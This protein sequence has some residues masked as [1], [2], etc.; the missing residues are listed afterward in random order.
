MLSI[1]SSSASPSPAPSASASP[2]L[3][4]AVT[5]TLTLTAP[6]VPLPPPPKDPPPSAPAAKRLPNESTRAMWYW[7]AEDVL[8][9][10][11][12]IRI[13]DFAAAPHG[14]RSRR[15]DRLFVEVSPSSLAGQDERRTRHFLASAHERGMQVELLAGAA[16][17]V[18]D[19]EKHVPKQICSDVAAYNSRNADA[20]FDGVHFDI[21]PHTLP[22][23]LW[24]ERPS[25]VPGD[26]RYNA[27]LKAN[28]IEI[29]RFCK[30]V[31]STSAPG[32]TLSADLGT[33]YAYYVH[34][35]W[36][37]LNNNETLLDYITIMNY[38]ATLEQWLLGA[39][40]TASLDGALYNIGA[41]SVP[42]LVGVETIPPP[43][44]PAEISFW[45]LGHEALHTMLELG[46]AEILA[47]P[48]AAKFGGV[49]I[50]HFES[51]HRMAAKKEGEGGLSCSAS[52][53]I[54]RVTGVEESIQC[55]L[56]YASSGQAHFARPSHDGVAIYN[57]Y[58][59]APVTIEFYR[60]IKN[61]AEIDC[62]GFVG[63][64]QC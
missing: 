10:D 26:D 18:L 54:L 56:F 23:G 45:A 42:V 12:G 20:A 9:T 64:H 57:A 38:F 7:S 17:W 48:S 44:A 15:I 31:L 1:V 36:K 13:L 24:R 58:A 43:H 21:E 63:D 47:Q 19:A 40:R 41:A 14:N 55:V 59:G 16:S 53:N 3:T 30:E 60:T 61:A 27:R 49:A 51:Y 5:F 29:M 28:Y 52:G 46:R 11:G 4:L 39:D 33:D 8:S 34:G 32:V 25:G 35:L 37:T 22:D 6:H 62:D 50:H 2:L